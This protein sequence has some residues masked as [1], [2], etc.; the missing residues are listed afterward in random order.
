MKKRVTRRQAQAW[1]APMRKCINDMRSGYSDAARGYAV[2]R[3]HEGD[4]YVRVDYCIAGF[5]AL[6]GRLFPTQSVQHMETIR[7]R[8]ASGVL[9]SQATLE[10]A[11][12]EL[13]EVEDLLITVSRL[14]LQSAVLTEQISIEMGAIFQEGAA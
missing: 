8:L 6:I 2:T 5:Q 14:D 1:L 13:R 4:D 11:L 10:G 7:K 12:R 3:L 9:V